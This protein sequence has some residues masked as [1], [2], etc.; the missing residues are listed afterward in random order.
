MNDS[1]KYFVYPKNGKPE[2]VLKCFKKALLVWTDAHVDSRRNHEH[3]LMF[4]D[5]DQATACR[6]WLDEHTKSIRW[7]IDN[8]YYRDAAGESKGNMK[9]EKNGSK[10]DIV[11][12]V[13]STD[14]IKSLIYRSASLDGVDYLIEGIPLEVKSV[15]RDYVYL[16]FFMQRIP[17]GKDTDWA[18]DS[19][20]S[21]FMKHDVSVEFKLK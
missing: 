13:K 21:A 18:L 4:N 9:V 2:T 12:M 6:T 15:S 17:E 19:I 11:V 10:Q 14:F 5:I 8:T 3:V 1:P 20:N 16:M 7:G